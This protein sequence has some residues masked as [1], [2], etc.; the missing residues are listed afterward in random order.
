MK[1]L[2]IGTMQNSRN[3]QKEALSPSIFLL[4]SI[5]VSTRSKARPSLAFT[6]SNLA[7]HDGEMCTKSEFG[8]L[9]IQSAFLTMKLYFQWNFLWN[10]YM[11]RKTNLSRFN[12]SKGL[13]LIP[14]STEC[15]HNMIQETA[16][17]LPWSQISLL[18][19]SLYPRSLCEFWTEL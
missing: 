10:V 9:H 19:F 12:S 4:E 17:D 5:T 1:G 6:K 13:G 3:Q 16:V 18:C 2:S 15:E 8:G 11:R 7:A 14:I